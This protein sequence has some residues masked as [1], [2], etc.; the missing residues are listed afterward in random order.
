MLLR[1]F[2]SARY[3]FKSVAPLRKIIQHFRQ[4]HPQPFERF[5]TVMEYDDGPRP[6]I[7]EYVTRTLPGSHGPVEIRAQYGPHDDLI[8]K[9]GGAQKGRLKSGDPSIRRPEKMGVDLPRGLPDIVQIFFIPRLPA[10][11]M[12]MRMIADPVTFG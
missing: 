11:D 5:F 10:I 9:R 1:A 8:F 6:R 12:V 2:S 7:P 3:R 4:C